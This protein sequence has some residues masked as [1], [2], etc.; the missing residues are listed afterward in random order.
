MTNY[1]DPRILFLAAIFAALT[2]L[3]PSAEFEE[4]ILLEGTIVDISPKRNG[5]GAFVNLKNSKLED[6]RLDISHLTEKN[7]DLVRALKSGDYIEAWYLDY[8]CWELK[9]KP[10]WQLRANG[11]MLKGFEGSASN[12]KIT[13]IMLA[14]AATITMIISILKRRKKNE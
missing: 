8:C 3:V 1:C 7:N 6:H 9:A 5:V 11:R 13:Q 4:L 2:L 10:V 12:S 14:I